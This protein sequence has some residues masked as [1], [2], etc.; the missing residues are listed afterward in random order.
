[1]PAVLAL[2][3]ASGLLAACTS[4]GPT[5]APST[6]RS[7][8]PPP[9]SPLPNVVTELNQL[10]E[11]SM[12][13]AV[14][15]VGSAATPND[16][17]VIGGYNAAGASTSGVYVFNGTSWS[18]GP[19]LPEAVNH[20]A[21]AAIGTTVIVAGGF[22]AAGATNRVFVLP[23]GARSWVEAAPMKRAR[24]ALTLLTVA[25]K[26]YAI[27]GLDGSSEVAIPEIFNPNT[28][29]WTDLPPMPNP[30]DHAAGY[31]DGS[32]ACVAGGRQPTTSVAIDCLDTTTSTWQAEVSLPTATS[33]AAAGIFGSL[34][35]VAGGEPVPETHLVTVV[36]ELHR[37]T[38]GNEPMLVPRHGTS[39][40][41]FGGRLWMCGGATAPAIHPTPDC[42]SIGL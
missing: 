27:G 38:W 17:Y 8:P 24:G 39:D 25:G 19:P 37:G 26:V 3:V 16:L 41:M 11:P 28:G 35:V 6:S 31:V 23:S 30:R 36:Q 7:A 13:A 12:P 40:A 34:I 14:Q 22:T 2:L 42:T 21:A 5:A 10:P 29:A 20:P 32:F 18:T 9:S 4:G 1:M 15:E 33:G